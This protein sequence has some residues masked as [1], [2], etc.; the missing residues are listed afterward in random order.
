MVSAIEPGP[1][2]A[3]SAGVSFASAIDYTLALCH[4]MK[5]LLLVATRPT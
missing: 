2:P 1:V 5:M 4:I 3:R